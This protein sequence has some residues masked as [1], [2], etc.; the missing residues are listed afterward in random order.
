[1]VKHMTRLYFVS[2]KYFYTLFCFI[3]LGFP[4]HLQAEC[5]LTL[6][7]EPNGAAPD[8]YRLYEREEGKKYH[9]NHYYDVGQES[10]CRVS[11]LSENVTYHFVVRAYAGSEM[12]DDSNEATYKCTTASSGN[13]PNPPSQPTTI[14]P[15]DTAQN[16]GLEP[17]LESGEYSDPDVGDG[18]AQTRW[19]IFR[20]DNDEC[21]YDVISN[22]DLTSLQVPPDTLEPFTAYYWKVSYYSQSGGISEPS[23]T[24]DFTTTLNETDST[25]STASLNGSGG[26]SSGSSDGLGVG[27]FIQSLF[28][29]KTTD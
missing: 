4:L 24:S 14:S 19:Q 28:L 2:R 3:I 18:H 17:I 9:D 10:S 25:N 22:S 20:L 5:Q 8:G 29:N 7:W 21:I 16:V 15:E 23:P 6:E 1:M 11:G 27:C 26:G 12:S 13:D